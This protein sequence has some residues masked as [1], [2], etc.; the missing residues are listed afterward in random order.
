MQFKAYLLLPFIVLAMACTSKPQ[1]LEKTEK[2]EDKAMAMP[3]AAPFETLALKK[4]NPKVLLQLAGELKPDRQTALFAK[5]NSYVKHIRVDIGSTVAAGQVLVELEAPEIESQLA[6]AAAKL[7]AQEAIYLATKA[8]YDRT[9]KAHETPGAIAKDALDV[10]KARK[11]ADEAQLNAA[12]SAYNEVK[13]M[14]GYLQIRA[15]FAGTVTARNVDIGAYV[16]PLHAAPLLVIED[17]KKLR[18][19]LSI[20]EANTPYVNLGDTILFYIRS[21]PQERYFARVS[22]KSGSLD[23]KLRSEKIEADFI[24]PSRAVKAHMIAETSLTLQHTEPTFFVPKSALVESPMQL[25]I[26]RVADG[27]AQ[28]VPVTK[29][30]VMPDMV[31]VFGALKSGDDVLKNGSEEIQNG[32]AIAQYSN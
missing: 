27:K 31:E 17:H 14:S 22:R 3:M 10:M 28:H 7:A 18:L 1:K 4:T 12:K 5:V 11:L 13:A 19:N 16:G 32:A 26:I 29:G 23:S 6:N 2:L 8:S 25:Y 20:A 9:V 30:R 15:P 24:N 21:Q